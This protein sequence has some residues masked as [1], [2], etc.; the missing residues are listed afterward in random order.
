MSWIENVE[1]EIF[2]GY[3]LTTLKMDQAWLNVTSN[4]PL[5]LY[6]LQT[7]CFKCPYQLLEYT[8]PSK[9]AYIVS[10][11]FE[12]IYRLRTTNVPDKIMP[13]NEDEKFCDIEYS[14][15]EFGVYEFIAKEKD[16]CEGRTHLDA[17][18]IYLPILL[19]FF[20]LVLFGI[21][22]HTIKRFGP[23]L[24][25]N[26]RKINKNEQSIM[27][28]KKVEKKRLR[29]I[30]TF[31]GACTLMMI[32]SNTGA[33]G[34]PFFAHIAWDGLYL[35]D[36]VM[37][38]FLWI[39]G[40][41]IPGSIRSQLRRGVPKNKI[42]WR[43]TVRSIKLVALGF[44]ENSTWGR[45]EFAKFRVFGVL[46]RFAFSYFVSS[47]LILYLVDFETAT[48]NLSKVRRAIKDFTLIWIPWIVVL[49]LTVVHTLITFLLEVPGCPT[50][51]VGPGGLHLFEEWHKYPHPENCAGGAAGYI[52]LKLFTINHIYDLPTSKATY[53]VAFF[54][55]EG[56][57]GFLTTVLMVWFGVQAGATML[58]FPK[59]K[60]R[61][62]RWSVWAVIT[63]AIT[64]ALTQVKQTDGW[65]PVNKNLWSVTFITVSASSALVILPILFY[66]IDIKQWW[67]GSPFT[68]AGMNAIL[69][70]VGQ[71][72][73]YNTLPF[74]F[75][76]PN[77]DRRHFPGLCVGTWTMVC[78]AFI[79]YWLDR[80]KMYWKV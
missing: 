49:G 62:I 37:S 75:K 63:G 79:A 64:A 33:G 28:D 12:K 32:F 57:L 44:L 42:L 35:I 40:V 54:D 34:Y 23:K 52:D 16:Q 10:T 78:W 69:L 45:I 61:V 55:P 20:A 65:I 15:G 74:A 19:V 71:W 27:D 66:I 73:F 68:E 51:Y 39:M 60:S 58:L 41:M 5:Y 30:D 80:K 11:A 59:F 50:G 43:V 2:D 18:N 67:S 25:S 47:A 13:Y 38:W 4:V 8:D 9:S 46:Q 70:Y 7:D 14:M 56:L 3:N 6:E 24:F 72:V 36:F 21:C 77:M 17:V 29:S 53:N 22:W 76:Y 26:A 31:R 48:E 1:N